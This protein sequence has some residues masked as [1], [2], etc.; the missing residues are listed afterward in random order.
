MPTLRAGVARPAA[1]TAPTPA[2]ASVSVRLIESC[3]T[4]IAG[5]ALIEGDKLWLRGEILRPDGS[6]SIT[7]ERRGAV[8]EGAAIGAALAEELLERAGPGFFG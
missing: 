8:T 3:E 1:P 2:W 7:G 5:L 6:A 4:P